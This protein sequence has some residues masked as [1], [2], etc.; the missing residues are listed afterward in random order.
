MNR[1]K[2]KKADE[3]T[4]DVMSTNKL[5]QRLFSVSPDF[6]KVKIYK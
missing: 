4:R 2:D 3:T 6:M 1:K 5:R